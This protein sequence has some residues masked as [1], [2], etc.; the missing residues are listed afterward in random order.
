MFVDFLTKYI[1]PPKMCLMLTV[2]QLIRFKYMV[3]YLLNMCLYDVYSLILTRPQIN[4]IEVVDQ[5]K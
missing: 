2:E 4:Q 1:G 5:E 3:Q